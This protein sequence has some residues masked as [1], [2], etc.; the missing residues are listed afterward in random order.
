MRALTCLPVPETCVRTMLAPDAS[1]CRCLSAAACSSACAGGPLPL[2]LFLRLNREVMDIRLVGTEAL[3]AGAG[4]PLAEFAVGASPFIALAAWP[5]RA[6]ERFRGT[7]VST[8]GA[9]GMAKY[10]SYVEL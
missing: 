8:L 9:G 10:S 3:G 6:V 1:S 4:A 7:T 2:L 5:P